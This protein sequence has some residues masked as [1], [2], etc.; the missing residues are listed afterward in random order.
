MYLPAKKRKEE[1]MKES[2]V[3][4][5]YTAGLKDEWTKAGVSTVIRKKTRETIRMWWGNNKYCTYEK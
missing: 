4:F 2:K 3:T 5:I 1:V